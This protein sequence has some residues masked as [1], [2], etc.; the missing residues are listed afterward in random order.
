MLNS[1]TLETTQ[2]SAS[3]DTLTLKKDS[4][5]IRNSNRISSPV[6]S[7]KPPSEVGFPG[8]SDN[9]ESACSAGDPSLIPGSGRSPGGGHGKPLQYS[10]LENPMDRGAWWATVHV[11]ARVRQ[12]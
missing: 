2:M 1:A 5:I 11:L 4:L 10:S 9:K 8:G 6:L 7:G 3:R 12:D